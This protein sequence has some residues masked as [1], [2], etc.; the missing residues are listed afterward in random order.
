MPRSRG[1]FTFGILIQKHLLSLLLL[2]LVD[3]E[4]SSK[5]HAHF[6]EIFR[7]YLT[8]R[9]DFTNDQCANVPQVGLLYFLLPKSGSQ[10]SIP[11]SK[12]PQVN[13][14]F[15]VSQIS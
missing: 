9:F 14:Y 10:M 3:H 6:S 2:S 11:A 8:D 7:D 15:S 5:N 4:G 12:L 13:H 1:D